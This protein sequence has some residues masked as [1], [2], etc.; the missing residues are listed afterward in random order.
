MKTSTLLWSVVVLIIL[1]LIAVGLSRWYPSTPNAATGTL[2]QTVSYACSDNKSITASY[3][4]GESKPASGDQPPVPGGSVAL[5]LSDGRQMTLPQTISADGTR[6]APADESLVFWSKGRTATITEG[7]QPT[8]TCIQLANDPGGL[9][10]AFES[11]SQ[12]FSLRYPSGYAADD[13]YK[14]QALGPGK[15]IYGTRFTIDPAI[16]TGTNLSPDSYLSVEE[17]P[18]AS[19]CSAALFVQPGAE[20]TGLSDGDLTYSY[21][22]TTDAGA[23]NR[24][25]EEIYAMPGTNPCVAVRYF[26]H[27]AAI[28]NYPEGSVQE[29]DRTKLLDQFDAMRRTL[30]IA[31]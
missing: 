14:Y 31:Q 5:T 13:G 17:I 7:T 20:V 23:G 16:A 11:G 27:Y 6:Y 30:M 25:E 22:S 9:P 15:E 18:Q 21:A 3:Y 10:Q 19:D 24:Y 1:A 29:F 28:E 8:Y 2:I 12:G 4:Q 26:I